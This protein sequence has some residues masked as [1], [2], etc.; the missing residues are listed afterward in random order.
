M[1]KFTNSEMIEL[2][3]IISS[4]LYTQSSIAKAYNVNQATISR[5]KTGIIWD[6]IVVEKKPE[7]KDGMD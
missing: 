3:K 5:I 6:T 2:K 7:V 1:A 4:G